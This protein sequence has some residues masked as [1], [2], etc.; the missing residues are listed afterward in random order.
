MTSPVST[1]RRLPV[2]KGSILFSHAG[3]DYLL[4]ERRGRGAE[5][6]QGYVAIPRTGG[7]EGEPVE[8]TVLSGRA[9][10]RAH[11][12]LE[13]EV[14]LAALLSHPAILRVLALYQGPD[15]TR[16]L[17]SEHVPGYLL[18]EVVDFAALRGQPLSEAFGLYLATEVAGVLHHAHTLK[19]G[20]GRALNI[21]HR[22]LCL[23]S[24]RLGGGGEVKL[25][26]FA[27]ASSLLP[28][29]LGTSRGRLRG[30]VEFAAPERLW[31]EDSSRVDARSDLFSL[32]LVLLEVMT[33]QHLYDLEE[34]E[35]A[36]DA[37]GARWVGLGPEARVLAEAWSWVSPEEMALRAA[38]FRPE[39]VERA[40][41]KLS[42]PVRQVLGR[43]LRRE[44]VERYA[45]AEALLEALQDCQRRLGGTP[46]GQ[47]EAQREVMQARRE[48]ARQ[49]GQRATLAEARG[50][51]PPEG[52]PPDEVSTRD[53]PT[54]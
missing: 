19:D 36:A 3:T 11:Q 54:R 53:V 28:G 20:A 45:S 52:L 31:G 29:R 42:G 17:L 51:A 6:L 40:A 14:Q 15:G 24:L 46:Y 43:L 37:R 2:R 5:G 44:P 27:F 18:S 7:V 26:D 32:G 50:F 22:D 34:V 38:V 21:L 39:H 47:R 10:W 49:G 13:E 30:T 9:P 8:V 25:S 4:M 41:R 35:K 1:P 33:G 48:A 16:Y 23:D 12:R